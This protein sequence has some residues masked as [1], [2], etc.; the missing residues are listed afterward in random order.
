[1][2]VFISYFQRDR[3]LVEQVERVLRHNGLDTLWDEN[4]EFGHG[5]PEQIKNFIAHA[6]VLMPIITSTSPWVHQE[7]GY[8]MAL[9]V[10]VLPVC[11]GELP[12]GLA[13]Q[14][15]ALALSEDPAMSPRQLSRETFDKLVSRAQR[16]SRPLYECAEQLED[17][18]L[19]MVE[20]AQNILELG[21]KSDV[22]V[23]HKGGLSSFHIPDA[24]PHHYHCLAVLEHTGPGLPPLPSLVTNPGNGIRDGASLPEVRQALEDK[25]L[26]HQRRLAP[27]RPGLA[28]RKNI[29]S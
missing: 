11:Q 28:G 21:A 25:H 12:A 9:N 3:K 1:L 18:T 17:R 24:L 20:Y 29:N 6:H 27:H 10:P 5:F 7:I 22:R 8:A 26:H 14:L 23:R 16:T 4:F 2:R 19:L 13:H 15:H